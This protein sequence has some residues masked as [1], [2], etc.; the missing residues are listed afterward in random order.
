S[1]QPAHSHQPPGLN[2]YL[3]GALEVPVVS[4]TPEEAAN[5]FTWFAH[6]AAIDVPASSQQ[7]QELLGWQPKQHG[8]IV[9]L[10]SGNYF[11]T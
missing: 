6:F 9:D 5:H 4:I 10:N 7:T 2:D 8:L 11:K 1:R 3:T